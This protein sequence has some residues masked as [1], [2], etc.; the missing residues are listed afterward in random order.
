MVH[1]G[2]TRLNTQ[3]GTHRTRH[4]WAGEAETQGQQVNTRQSD[5]GGQ[6]QEGRPDSGRTEFQN[7]TMT[8]QTKLKS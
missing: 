7:K 6:T 5:T 4:S 1:M 2:K 8:R 3:K